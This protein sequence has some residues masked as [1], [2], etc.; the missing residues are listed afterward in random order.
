MIS[1]TSCGD[2]TLKGILAIAGLSTDSKP[3]TE[4]GKYTIMNGSTFTEM[5]TGKVYM[6]SEENHTWYEL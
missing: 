6:F 3:T 4:I 2:T 5:D 1:I